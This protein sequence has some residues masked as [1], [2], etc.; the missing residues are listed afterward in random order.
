MAAIT[1]GQTDAKAKKAG[2]NRRRKQASG[3][4]PTPE[5]SDEAK[6]HSRKAAKVRSRR[7]GGAQRS[8][9]KRQ[10]KRRDSR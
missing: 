5:Q 4:Q 3:K 7:I 2:S 10:Q 6:A 8:E 1:N 9:Q